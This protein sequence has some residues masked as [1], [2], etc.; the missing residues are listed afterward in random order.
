MEI[1]SPLSLLQQWRG[2]LDGA[3]L[4]ELL[5]LGYTLDLTFIEQRAV[6]LARGLGARVT[7]LGDGQHGIHDPVDIRQAGRS[8]QHAHVACAGAFHPKLALLVGDEDVWAAIGSGNPTTAGWGFNE[9]LW[10]VIRYRRDSGPPA[11]AQLASWMTAL[12]QHPSIALPS[13]IATTVV[14][15]AAKVAP[16]QA[17][18]SVRDL[19]V[20]GNL[21][22]PLLGQLPVGPVTSLRLSAPFFDHDGAAVRA[23]IDRMQPAETIIGLQPRLSSYDG[24]TL[25]TAIEFAP[26]SQFRQ[27]SE[28]GHRIS[29]GKL[30]EWNDGAITMAMVGSPNL[31]RAALLRPVDAGG[32]CEL[33]AI[34]PV[35][36]TLL[37]EGV[38]L[39]HDDVRARS[40]L[41][42]VVDSR[43][44]APVTLLGARRIDTTISVELVAAVTAAVTFE[45][46]SSAAPGEWWPRHQIDVTGARSIVE[47]RFLTA[48]AAGTAVRAVARFTG[49]TYT[50]PAVFLTDTIK[51]QSRSGQASGPRLARDYAQIFTDPALLARF[52]HDFLTLLRVNAVHRTTHPSIAVRSAAVVD[53][54]RWG[55]W[56]GRTETVLGP[57]L[58]AGLFPTASVAASAQSVNLWAI[59][60]DDPGAASVEDEEDLDHD[61]E[62]ESA[63]RQPPNIPTDQR[64][65]LRQ[66]AAR[67]RRAVTNDPAPSV[68]LRMLVT[69]LHFDLLAGGVWGP[70]DDE[71]LQCLAEILI[72]TPPTGSDDMPDRG[73]P[74]LGSLVAVGLALMSGE[75]TLHGGRPQDIMFQHVWD[76]VSIWAALANPDLIDHYLYQPAQTY[77]R[78]ADRDQV[79]RVIALA[80]AAVDDPNA[81]LRAAL[82]D[83]DI[84]ADLLGGTWVTECGSA[85]PRRSA[86]RLATLVGRHQPNYAALARGDRGTC[87]L[88]CAGSTLVVAESTS[89]IWRVAE[90]PTATSNPTSMF[91]EGLPSGR[92]YPR[93]PGASLPDQVAEIAAKIGVDVVQLT[94]A[95]G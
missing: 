73:E 7:L 28:E 26:K 87:A 54:D 68:E 57:S 19:Q 38:S 31:S 32:N 35:P 69:Q 6:G 14:E 12:A 55:S 85:P 3:G 80:E 63:R 88:L 74:Y 94:V 9:E 5:I 53:D 33:A 42:D 71:W 2:R 90:K 48:E 45:V 89:R 95:L 37:P 18:D 46:S 92:T 81:R 44:A 52:E 91:S 15:I 41:A 23:L 1:H 8:Y 61:E 86:V 93:R 34:Y 47:T 59:D 43:P 75:A 51:C 84:E 11:M 62:E 29:H 17:D 27:L 76:E 16:Q 40:T 4:Q 49:S 77:S 70:D 66:W 50:S 79:D 36:E 56:L 13:W 78:T 72:S 30:I 39:P 60:G 24:E 21:E 10:I 83:T 22:R 64:H 67:L 58:L 65:Q 20:L 25:T 82:D